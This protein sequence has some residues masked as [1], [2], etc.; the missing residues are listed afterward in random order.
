MLTLHCAAR[1]SLRPRALSSCVAIVALSFLFLLPP[2]GVAVANVTIGGTPVK[3]IAAATYYSFQPAATDSQVRALTFS[4]ANKP[5]WARFDTSTGRLFGTSTPAN[6]GSFPGIV[7]S[8][9]DGI[10]HAVLPAFSVVVLPPAHEGSVSLGWQP[11]TQNSDSSP[12]TNL[13]GYRVYFGTAPTAL[14]SRL[15]FSSPGIARCVVSGLA[16]GTWY[17]AVS[18]YNSSGVEGELSEIIGVMAH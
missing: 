18:A 11:P 6:V 10:D 14:S 13:A 7:I 15:D 2:A 5:A 9:S 17:F 1:G 3:S 8:V 4:I 12:L 16:A